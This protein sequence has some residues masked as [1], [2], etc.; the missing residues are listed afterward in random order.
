MLHKG[1]SETNRQRENPERLISNSTQ[2]CLKLI[3][4][5]RWTK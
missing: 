5:F 1:S 4:D 2:T 3:K